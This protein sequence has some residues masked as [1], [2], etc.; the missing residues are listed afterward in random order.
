MNP[1]DKYTSQR[2][3]IP[4]FPKLIF[5]INI[6]SQRIAELQIVKWDSKSKLW[7]RVCKTRGVDSLGKLSE[8]NLVPR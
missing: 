3:Q 8:N 5:A 4:V 1:R 2:D 6:N 7:D